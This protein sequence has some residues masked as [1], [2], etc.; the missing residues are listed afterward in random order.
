[1]GG[2]RPLAL[3]L[4]AAPLTMAGLLLVLTG[5]HGAM[6]PRGYENMSDALCCARC[7]FSLRG[8]GS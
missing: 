8:S 6:A 7:G 5:P 4:L 1:M 2:Q 3:I